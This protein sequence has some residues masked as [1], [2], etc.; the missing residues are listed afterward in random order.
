[1]SAQPAGHLML[2]ETDSNGEI[3][4]RAKAPALEELQA[5]VNKLADE[6][7]MAHRDIDSK[8]RRILELERDR[9]AERLEYERYA[10]VERVATY[11]HRKCRPEDYARKRP[12]INPMS[13]DRFDAV[14]G[15][16]DQERL[17]PVPGKKRRRREPAYTLEDCKLAIDGAAF[18]AFRKQRKNGTWEVFNDL[19]LVFRSGKHFESFRDRAPLPPEA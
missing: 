17:V 7:K 18:D 19:E 16:L 5:E 2:V 15:I 6:L 12:K 13:P 14:R 11:W 10:D 8:N 4:G 9:A 1:M 3:V